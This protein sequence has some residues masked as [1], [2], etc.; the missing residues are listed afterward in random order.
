[1]APQPDAAR[2]AYVS[3]NAGSSGGGGG[4]A[5]LQRGMKLADVTNL[6]GQGQVTSQSVSPDGLRTQVIEY[7]TADSLV[8]VTFVE[9]VVVKYSINSR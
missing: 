7:T 1:M 6:M 5:Q 4:V 2:P 3:P 8:D 9:G